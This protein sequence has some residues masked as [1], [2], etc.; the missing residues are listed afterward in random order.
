MF[1]VGNDREFGFLYEPPLEQLE[2][3]F[4]AILSVQNYDVGVSRQAIELCS[5]FKVPERTS[6]AT[7]QARLLEALWD[8]DPGV[9][10][11]A[12]TVVRREL[13]LSGAEKNPRIVS[14]L[15]DELRWPGSSEKRSAVLAAMSRNS[16][17]RELP[18]IKAAIRSLLPLPDAAAWL[19]P[20]LGGA[21]FSDAERLELLDRG[22]NRLDVPQRLAAL[23]LLFA[24]PALLDRDDPPASAVELLRRA[25]TDPSAS[26][27]ERTLEGVKRL[28]VFWGGRSASQLLLIALADD[29]PA[30]RRLGLSLSS[31][32]TTFW[33]RPDALEHLARLLV[34]P[35][36][37]VRSLALDLVKHHRLVERH[38]H[39]ARRIKAA[40]SDP[41]LA[42]RASAVLRAAGLDPGSVKADVALSRPRLLS[43]ATFRRVVN[44]LFYQA[45]EDG[46][47]CAKCHGNHTILQLAEVESGKGMT[48]DQLMVNY[49]SALKVVNLGEPESSLILR[50]PL[51]P[52]GQGGPDPSS[53]TGLTHVGGPRWDSP[54]HPAYRAILSWIREAASAASG[55]RAGG[56]ITADSHAPGYEPARA[57]DGDLSTIWHTEFIGAMPG[58]PHELTIDLGTSR[59][60]EGLL[61]VPR[62]DSSNGRVRDFEVRVSRDGKAWSQPLASGRWAD[63]PTFKLV[64]LPNTVARFVQLRGLSEVNGLPVMSAA[65]VVIDA[66]VEP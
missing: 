4:A 19:M 23:D 35:D 46:Q 6:N 27:R 2:K 17:L 44:P 47:S 64:S 60:V 21:E 30:I 59:R 63:D 56:A 39:L 38:P 31:S 55:P 41:G 52:Q 7:I 33:S 24:R 29:T 15:L 28:P 18:E 5:F 45:S 65:E 40:S 49:N 14:M 32:K 22:W 13:A 34:D 54:D 37:Q 61:Y 58:Y 53:A 43:L 9:R 62:Q 48:G 50:K 26:V 12:R 51:S 66:M 57:G 11:A 42:E 36:S 16:L 25:A 20:V 1:D 8:P 10:E 3:T